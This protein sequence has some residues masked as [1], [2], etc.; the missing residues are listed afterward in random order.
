MGLRD[1]HTY[2]AN[3]GVTLNCC[4]NHELVHL[5]TWTNLSAN[6][7]LIQTKGFILFLEPF[8]LPYIGLYVPVSWHEPEIFCSMKLS[9]GSR[10]SGSRDMHVACCHWTVL[11]MNFPVLC[12]CASV[13]LKTPA[14][15]LRYNGAWLTLGLLTTTNGWIVHSLFVP[16][17]T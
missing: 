13:L 11:C 1:T 14:V 5:C 17:S 15:N 12:Y 9:F 10:V 8:Y 6:W 4:G 7:I 16:K 3:W 2:I